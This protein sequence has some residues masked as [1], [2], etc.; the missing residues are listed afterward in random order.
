MCLPLRCGLVFFAVKD[1]FVTFQFL[2]P[3]E[4]TAGS[5][6]FHSMENR[7]Q[8][9]AVMAGWK[10]GREVR[11]KRKRERKE[12]TNLHTETHTS[13]R[14]PSESVCVSQKCVLDC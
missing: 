3:C 1:F 10:K 14:D 8:G 11:A 5:V 2:A 7:W 6:A 13:A 4:C 9:R 12:E